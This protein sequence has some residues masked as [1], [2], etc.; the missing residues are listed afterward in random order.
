MSKKSLGNG[1]VYL[2]T[3][4]IN[5]AIPFLLLPILTRVLT[6]SDY[7]LITMFTLMVTLLGALAGLSIHGAVNIRFFKMSKQELSEYICGSLTILIASSSLI[8]LFIILFSNVLFKLTLLSKE[9]LLLACAV[10]ACQFLINIKLA[11][12]QVTKQAIKYGLFKIL[13]SLSNA[14][15][16]LYFIFIIAESWGGRSIGIALSI[17]VFAIIS[18]LLLFKN[19]DL[20]LK[21]N[22][23]Q[24]LDAL[25][26][27]VPL[28]PHTLGAVTISMIDRFFIGNILGDKSVGIY[29]VGLQLAMVLAVLAD[30]FSKAYGPWLYQ[31]LNTETIENKQLIVGICYIVFICFLFSIAPAYIFLKLVFPYFIGE[32]FFEAIEYVIWFLIGYAFVGMYYA[33]A[34]FYFFKNKTGQLSIITFSTGLFSIFITY[35]AVSHWGLLGGAISFA[36]TNVFMFSLVL[37]N[38]NNVIKLPW[39]EVRQVINS[40]KNKYYLEH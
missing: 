38:V 29:M 31:K 23:E 17:F 11:L 2:V 6:P 13:L 5:A 36:L 32:A 26:F 10:A 19:K 28:V 1:I 30:A 21:L 25:R 16:S 24:M 20:T 18:L 12:W 4:I 37:F 35:I 9:W 8:F 33:I 27:G 39:F 22:K 14:L 7:G 15:L 3:N 34:G 40:L